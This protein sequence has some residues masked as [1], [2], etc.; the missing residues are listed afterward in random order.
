MFSVWYLETTSERIPHGQI[1]RI[2]PG[3]NERKF[4]VNRLSKRNTL[5]NEQKMMCLAKEVSLQLEGF[6]VSMLAF[7][8]QSH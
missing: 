7:E 8:G 6:L 2:S 4:P 5:E 1:K 3:E